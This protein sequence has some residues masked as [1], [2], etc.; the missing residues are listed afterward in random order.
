VVKTVWNPISLNH[1]QSVKKLASHGTAII[2]TKMRPTIQRRIF[3][4]DRG[5]GGRVAGP[6]LSNGE[7]MRKRKCHRDPTAATRPS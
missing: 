3:L 5:I 6:G 4:K 2:P 7:L 1:S